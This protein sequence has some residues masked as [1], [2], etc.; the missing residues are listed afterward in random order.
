MNPILEV[1]VF[2]LVSGSHWHQ[3]LPAI[4]S[5]ALPLIGAGVQ[6]FLKKSE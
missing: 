4:L 1:H 2:I 3:F 5:A 6:F